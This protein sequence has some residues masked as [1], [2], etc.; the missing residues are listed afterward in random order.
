[1]QYKRGKHKVQAV[2]TAYENA[3][4]ERETLFALIVEK[5]QQIE[6][7][8]EKEERVVLAYQRA[9]A[10][11][12][13]MSHA[14]FEGDRIKDEIERLL[15]KEVLERQIELCHT[16]TEKEDKEIEEA[17]NA[18]AEKR[19]VYTECVRKKERLTE[20]YH[21]GTALERQER[22]LKEELRVAGL[23][24]VKMQSVEDMRVRYAELMAEYAQVATGQDTE[25]KELQ[26]KLEK[27]EKEAFS[28]K[29][30]MELL[31]EQMGIRVVPGAQQPSIA[32][33]RERRNALEEALNEILEQIDALVK[34]QEE[35]LLA[36]EQAEQLVQEIEKEHEVLAMRAEKCQRMKAELVKMQHQVQEILLD[37]SYTS[38][39]EAEAA[40]ERFIEEQ[41]RKKEIV[42]KAEQEYEEWKLAFQEET[43]LLDQLY[44]QRLIQMQKEQLAMEEYNNSL[45]NS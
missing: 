30:T 12:S 3:K 29:A 19:A 13:S 6:E 45:R 4:K 20:I 23:Q 41:E 42:V 7:L 25:P 37:A 1:M 14:M 21:K 28:E 16:E 39:Q 8:K 26:A 18:L 44:G 5:E 17:E 9:Q 33:F 10:D 43:A 22:E 24:V 40:M 11:R 36:R 31:L 35:C 27:I 2:K 38:S 15:Q 32:Q 34:E